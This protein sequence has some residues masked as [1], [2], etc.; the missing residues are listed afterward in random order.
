MDIYV[1]VLFVINLLMNSVVLLL[2]GFTADIKYKVWRILLAGA[3]GSGYVLVSILPG[4][5]IVHHFLFKIS[6]SL[7]LLLLAFGVKPRR[8]M[9]LLMAFFYV[10]SF[11]LGGAVMGWL[12]FSQSNHYLGSYSIILIQPSWIQLL[13][14]SLVGI[15]LI[16]IVVR[17]M[18]GRMAR[19]QHLYRVKLEYEG[20]RIERTAFLDTG[21]GLYTAVSHKPIILVTQQAIADV[22]SPQ[23]RSFLENNTPD[24][25]IANLNQ[26]MDLPWLSR[27]Q[28]IPYHSIGH[29]SV[30]LVFRIDHFI[31]TGKDG[32]IQIGDVMVGIYGGTLSEDGTYEVLLHPQIINKLSKKE[33]ANLCA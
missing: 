33:E 21:N 5:V 32:D 25:W 13:C 19:H 26:C 18:I 16:L 11:I 2:T 8:T 29:K 31:L 23:V 3:V 27:V 22:L 30:L 15:C 28:I 20:R 17:R 10:I 7:V 14:G 12:Y 6:M 9:L 24:M 1:D 4:V